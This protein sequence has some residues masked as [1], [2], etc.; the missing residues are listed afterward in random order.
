[1]NDTSIVF[2]FETLWWFSIFVL[3]FYLTGTCMKKYGNNWY[4]RIGN[5]SYI[6]SSICKLAFAMFCLILSD[7]EC[8]K[9]CHLLFHLSNKTK[10][11]MD[12]KDEMHVANGIHP[13]I[14][15]TFS[16]NF[17][18]KKSL[19][20]NGFWLFFLTIRRCL[21]LLYQRRDRTTNCSSPCMVC[22]F[23]WY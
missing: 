7:E 19:G 23:K 17:F 15:Q 13:T 6:W 16:K 5:P 22:H 9:I 11:V 1:M 10:V 12:V 2:V 3:S 14:K 8:W 21:N 4:W 18:K 20:K